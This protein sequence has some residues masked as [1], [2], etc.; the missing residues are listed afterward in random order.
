MSCEFSLY[1]L[2]LLSFYR[3][4]LCQKSLLHF[5]YLWFNRNWG[6]SVG[7][8][9]LEILW[10][11]YHPKINEETWIY[12]AGTSLCATSP[13]RAKILLYK[14]LNPLQ[15]PT[16]Y[17]K[18]RRFSINHCW[19]LEQYFLTLRNELSQD[20]LEEGN[21]IHNLKEKKNSCTRIFELVSS[22]SFKKIVRR[23]LLI[24]P[25]SNFRINVICLEE[26]IVRIL[27]IF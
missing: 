14:S 11:R 4:I 9:C 25:D 26:I 10:I 1:W 16:P 17:F 24:N 12:S 21:I 22:A 23:Y 13:S 8:S 18:Q 7:E 19:Y 5:P 3:K 15:S 6:D 20:I 2:R 27:C